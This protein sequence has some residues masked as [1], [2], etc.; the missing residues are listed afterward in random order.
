MLVETH[1]SD[2]D[3]DAEKL[4]RFLSKEMDSGLILDGAV[5]SEPA[6]IQVTYTYNNKFLLART[7]GLVNK[8][9]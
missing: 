1:G 8:R 9:C 6:K 2:D 5:T 3:H 4:N 7:M